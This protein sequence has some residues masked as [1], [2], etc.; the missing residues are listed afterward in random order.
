ELHSAAYAIAHATTVNAAVFRQPIFVTAASRYQAR[1]TNTYG[2]SMTVP[3]TRWRTVIGSTLVPRREETFQQIAGRLAEP[4][5]AEETPRD[6]GRER[7]IR[8]HARVA[9]GATRMKRNH[10]LPARVDQHRPRA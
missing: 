7:W 4:R 3:T 9:Q 10:E 1:K 8:R 6:G 2:R 5:L